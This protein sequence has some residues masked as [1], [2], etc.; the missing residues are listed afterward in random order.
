MCYI[1]CTQSGYNGTVK[2]LYIEEQIKHKVR[3]KVEKDLYEFWNL[4]EN[5]T[6]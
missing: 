2:S 6:Y 4:D 5:V 1:I 3:K